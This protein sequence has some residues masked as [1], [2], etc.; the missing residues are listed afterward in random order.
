MDV[1]KFVEFENKLRAMFKG[2]ITLSI[3]DNN[4]YKIETEYIYLTIIDL[5]SFLNLLVNYNL[6]CLGIGVWYSG[7]YE[8]S[9]IYLLIQDVGKSL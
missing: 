4:L 1:N 6:K 5:N 8:T 2:K 7:I 9:G 3:D